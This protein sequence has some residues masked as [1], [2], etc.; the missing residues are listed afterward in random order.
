[1][2]RMRT[3][4]VR[5]AILGE[6]AAPGGFVELLRRN[7]H[8][9]FPLGD[10]PDYEPPPERSVTALAEAQRRSVD[11]VLYDLMLQRDG[12]EL[13]YLPLLDYSA[14]N[15]DAV[16]EMLVHPATVLGLGDGGAHC[17]V[18]CDASLPT[19]MLAHWARDRSRGEQLPVETVV[20]LQTRR[21]AELY[22]FRDRGLLAPGYLADLNIVDH[23]ALV[24]E[25]PE[26]VYDLPA[27]GKR[28]VQRARGYAATIKS[29]VVVREHDDATGELPGRL[30][31]GPQ[32]QPVT[33]G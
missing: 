13:L 26:M 7:L 10:P 28:L 3:P 29:G 31:R 25:S 9:L 12:R 18:L 5:A 4:E 27:Q 23:D 33:A 19:F 21:T 20:H 11:E 24:L 6:G 22:G 32:P 30:L 2:T 17:G 1:V 15:L 8:K 16:R 14:G